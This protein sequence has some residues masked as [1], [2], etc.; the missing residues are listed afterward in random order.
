MFARL[1]HRTTTRCGSGS[2]HAGLVGE[3]YY[4]DAAA[5]FELH[6]DSLDVAANRGLLDHELRGD[7][8]VREPPRDELE[9]LPLAGSELGEL[10]LIGE[11]GDRLLGHAVDHPAGYRRREQG[12]SAGDR[13]HR[14]DQ[15]LRSRSLEQESR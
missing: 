13:V 11:L 4:L 14:R 12:V 1:T 9:D 10:G 2:V 5:E 3:D 8:A 6:Q 7:L 15:L